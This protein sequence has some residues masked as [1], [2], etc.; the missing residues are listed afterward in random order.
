MD[1]TIKKLVSE[2][3]SS[4]QI[5]TAIGIKRSTLQYRLA[6]LGLKTRPSRMKNRMG[7]ISSLSAELFSK[8]CRSHNSLAGILRELKVAVH[9]TN[10]RSLKRR[11]AREGVDISHIQLGLS[12][13]KGK[14]FPTQ[15]K[16]EFLER[17]RDG[18]RGI[19]MKHL[20]KK[21][22]EFRLLSYACRFC[23]TSDWRGN[24]LTLEIDH[25]DGNH[26]N[27]RISNLRFLCPNC[28]SQTKTFGNRRI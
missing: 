11:I 24:P 22:L 23:K 9:T 17:L 7:P 21:I 26:S 5:A 10:Y 4:Y 13:R 18:A 1:E 3:F 6:K 27:N 14:R 15:T 28:H 8:L 16:E 25:I 19:C 12:A 2:G 20:R